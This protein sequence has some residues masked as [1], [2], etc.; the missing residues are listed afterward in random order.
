MASIPAQLGLNPAE[1][2]AYNSMTP[3][4]TISFNALPDNNAKI[5]YVQALVERDRTWRE[6]S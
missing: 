5:G 1:T 6:R 4:E 3:R 2:E